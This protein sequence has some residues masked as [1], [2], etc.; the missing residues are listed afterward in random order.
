MWVSCLLD[1]RC[2]SRYVKV[3]MHDRNNNLLGLFND[4]VHASR[5]RA[6]PTSGFVFKI[7]IFS[8]YVSQYVSQFVSQFSQY[9]SH[10]FQPIRRLLC[11]RNNIF[12]T[13]NENVF[14]G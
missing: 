2:T 11:Q 1:G 14:L 10:H 7:N 4:A 9:V 13:L 3:N 12:V 6:T 5:L 8:Q